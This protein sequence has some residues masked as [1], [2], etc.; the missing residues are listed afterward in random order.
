MTS[1]FVKTHQYFSV[2]FIYNFSYVN[3]MSDFT[4]GN[5]VVTSSASGVTVEKSFDGEEFAVPAIKFEIASERDEAVSVRI[6]DRI[7]DDFPMD[8]VGFHPE[9]ENDNWT[10]YKDHRVQFER[11]L[12]AG[13]TLTTVYGIRLSNWQEAEQFLRPPMV[14][15]VGASEEREASDDEEVADNTIT[16][17]VSEDSSQVVRDVIAGESD[18]PGLGDDGDE[19]GSDDAFG[20]DPLADEGS[21]PLAEADGSLDDPLATGPEGDDDPLGD[22]DSL[23][24]PLGGDDPLA[25]DDTDA[26]TDDERGVDDRPADGASVD[27]DPLASGDSPEDDPLGGDVPDDGADAGDEDALALGESNEEE[28]GRK[29][30]ADA[31]PAERDEDVTVP[32]R[33]TSPPRP[34]SVAAALADEIRAGEVAEGDLDVLRE[35]LDL[36]VPESTNVRLRHLQSRVDDLSA[37][38]EA[39]EKF[40]DENGT[41]QD[42][43]DDFESEVDALREELADVREGVENAKDDGAQTRARVADLEDD[44]AAVS[45]ETDRVEDLGADLEDVR[46]DLDGVADLD[47]EVAELREELTHLR[48][49]ETDV[50]SVREDV[51][52]LDDLGERVDELGN[53]RDD[54]EDLETGLADVRDDAARVEDLEADLD[55][56]ADG[57]DNLADGLD[58]IADVGEDVEQLADQLTDLEDLVAQNTQETAALDDEV[59]DLRDDLEEA[60]SLEDDIATLSSDVDDLATSLSSTESDLADRIE[61]VR[62][63]VADIESELAELDEW[64]EDLTSLQ[65]LASAAASNGALAVYSETRDVKH[66]A[67]GYGR[68]GRR[69]R[70]TGTVRRPAA[71]TARR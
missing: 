71:R 23:D 7:P 46:E 20:D 9:F 13:E 10:A 14:D 44:V 39:L 43:V 56:L 38:T 58:S 60:M 1:A 19:G 36:E 8:N 70:R 33:Q 42:V 47:E 55:N 54:L 29:P 48:D 18:L 52:R 32:D 35:E 63:D 40:I 21:D 11:V 5:E 45:E 27:A 6:T 68:D 2:C 65:L 30:A 64:R 51:E 24:D 25:G 41:A 59:E 61:S 49:L 53:L 31:E 62:G 12:D 16:D 17:I 3:C 37:Y 67:W 26:L 50:E 69:R 57:L 66:Q 22:D 34:G 4:E 28:T 15:A